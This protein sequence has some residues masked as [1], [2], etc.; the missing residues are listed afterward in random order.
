MGWTVVLGLTA[1]LI[2]GR[3]GQAA[4]PAAGPPSIQVDDPD[5]DRASRALGAGKVEEALAAIRQGAAKHPEWPP[6]RLILARLHFS[7]NQPGP[8]RQALE[9]AAVEEPDHP[10]V[11]LT[12][13]STAVNEGRLHDGELNCEKA[14]AIADKM[15]ADSEKAR[16]TRRDAYAGLATVAEN[17]RQWEVARQRIHDWLQQDDKS[18]AAHQRMGRA[19]F[20]LGRKEEAVKELTRARELDPNSDPPAV[21]MAQLAAQAGDQAGAGEW[22]GRAVREEPKSVKVQIA[23]AR[24]L[25]D[26][27]RLDEARS[28]IDQAKTLDPTT[29]D[30]DRLRGLIAWNRRDFAE[31]ESIFSA[32]H[33][34]LPADLGVTN[35]LAL[36][37]T[38]QDDSAKRAQALQLAEANVRQSQTSETLGTLARAQYRAGKLEDA[39][40]TLTALSTTGNG[41]VAADTVF[42][43]ARIL[44][45]RSRVDEAKN[46]LRSI[47]SLPGVF[48]YRREAQELLRKLDGPNE[49]QPPAAT[50][51]AS[52][53]AAPRDKAQQKKR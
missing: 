30:V 18:V 14:L 44:A 48:A 8:G 21:S 47:V 43:G 32:L 19:L 9:A 20:H 4:K 38:E 28:A 26:S 37:L 3:V 10:D 34:E 51:P 24:W 16:N 13:A 22:L 12:F 36:S 50:K 35:L 46:L 17:R 29:K 45:D 41:Q 53:K 33:K 11:I 7:L 2:A 27:D 49:A 52:S 23:R 15:P 42:F 39:E 5:L 25:I 6:A 40:R 1:T 31:A